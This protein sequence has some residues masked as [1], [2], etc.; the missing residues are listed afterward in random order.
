MNQP[1]IS[2]AQQ[3]ANVRTSIDYLRSLGA[4]PREV[5]AAEAH[6]AELVERHRQGELAPLPDDGLPF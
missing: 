3:L 4:P 2:P 5:A 6:L 1:T